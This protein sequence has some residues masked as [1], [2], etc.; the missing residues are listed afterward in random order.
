MSSCWK[1]GAPTP[2]GVVECER[3]AD[4][5]PLDVVRDV[6][7]CG[8]DFNVV[9]KMRP[10]PARIKNR[11]EAEACAEAVLAWLEAARVCFEAGEIH[12]FCEP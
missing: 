10:N 2:D 8:R 11:A 5:P 7:A 9:F 3:C 12:K 4:G 1:C 6:C